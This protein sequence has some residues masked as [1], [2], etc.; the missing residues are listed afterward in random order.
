MKL[1]ILI[2]ETK[3]NNIPS[4]DYY[5]QKTNKKMGKAKKRGLMRTAPYICLSKIEVHGCGRFNQRLPLYLESFAAFHESNATKV[6]GFFVLALH[7]L[8]SCQPDVLKCGEL[9]PH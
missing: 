4:Q 7:S 6:I 2:Y 1:L 9:S 5:L 8:G 3:F